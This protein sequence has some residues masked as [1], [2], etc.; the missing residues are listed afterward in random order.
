VREWA[1]EL[2]LAS[3]WEADAPV[4]IKYSKDMKPAKAK[5]PA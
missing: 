1:K 5:V 4:S 2:D 3:P